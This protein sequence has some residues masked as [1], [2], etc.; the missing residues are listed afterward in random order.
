MAMFLV[1]S[2]TPPFEA[3]Y[4]LPPSVPSIP[5]TDAMFTMLPERCSIIGT[6]ACFDTRNVPSRLTRTRGG[7]LRARPCAQARRPRHPPR[8]R[9]V[10]PPVRVATTAATARATTSSSVTSPTWKLAPGAASSTSSHRVASDEVEPDDLCTLVG[11]PQ[12]GRLAD[13]RCR[14]GHERDRP[15]QPS[16]SNPSHPFHDLALP[17]GRCVRSRRST[18]GR[19]RCTR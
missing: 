19:T 5:S 17:R 13:A 2:T 14:A 4:A 8:S 15:F 16:H 12:R 3:L 6:S 10:E 18:T 1:S 11:E 9:R 7:T